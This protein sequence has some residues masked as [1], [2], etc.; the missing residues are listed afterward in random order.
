MAVTEQHHADIE[1]AAQAL[2]E[3]VAEALRR[4]IAER[5]AASLVVS[6]GKSPV[7]F[8]H[9]LR[10]Q[11]L[12]WSKVWIT[13]ADERWVPP[14]SPDS[15]EHLLRQHLIRDAVLDARLVSLWTRDEKAIN[16][17]PE[18]ME[19]IGRMPR[20]F[21]AVV[22]GM[23]ED[24]HTASLFPGNSALEA[25]LNPRWAL[26]VSVATAPAAPTSRITLTMRS[27]VDSRQLFLSIAGSAKRAIYE[28]ARTA[29]PTTYPVAAVLQQPYVPVTVHL[30]D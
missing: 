4:G 2:A 16:A 22:L 15:N 18:V 10:V 19:R 20:P 25:M 7:P 14:S 9:A 5:G 21:D 24:G 11:A 12:D 6:G 17:V 1:S 3:Q 8:F 30:V 28:L 27:L 23:G 29:A 13:L 26:T